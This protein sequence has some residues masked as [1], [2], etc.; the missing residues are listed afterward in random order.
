MSRTSTGAPGA[1]SPSTRAAPGSLSSTRSATWAAVSSSSRCGARMSVSGPS[2]CRGEPR[3]ARAGGCRRGRRSRPRASPAR[4][5]GSPSTH[6]VTPTSVRPRACSSAA[7]RRVAP[8]T[9]SRSMVSLGEPSQPSP[10]R[11]VVNGP[12]GRLRLRAA[13]GCGRVPRPRS[14]SRSGRRPPAG[15]RTPGRR[16]GALARQ[17]AR[18]CAS[19]EEGIRSR[20]LAAGEGGAATIVR[21]CVY[22]S[23]RVSRSRW[24]EARA[25]YFADRSIRQA[26][27]AHAGRRSAVHRPRRSPL[28]RRRRPRRARRRARDAVLRLQRA[29]PAGQ[30]RGR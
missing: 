10:L 20:G 15:T 2:A 14:A 30:R 29:P 16:A 26:G 11:L 7:R 27:G 4:R 13:A 17:R 24:D 12:A 22:H 23:V 6:L 28:L 5:A 21:A 8:A 18:R 3:P 9:A 1:C 19:E 25:V